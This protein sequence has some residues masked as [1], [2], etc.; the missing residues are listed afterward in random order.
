[1]NNLLNY[2]LKDLEKFFIKELNEKSFR[3]KQVFKWIYQQNELD[4][5]LMNNLSKSLRQKLIDLT[6]LT[7]PELVTEQKSQDGT[8]KW[9]FKLDSSNYIETVF[10]PEKDYS[11]ANPRGTLCISSQVGCAL[12]C[13][14]CATAQQG[15]NRNLSIAEIISQL[16]LAEF[17]LK[18]TSNKR[19]I[20]NI[21]FMGMGEPLLNF[22]NVIKSIQIMMDDFAYG[23][24]WKRITVSTAGVIPAINKLKEQCPV[25]LAISLHATNDDLRNELVPLN[26]KY[27]LNE[28][29]CS[30][31]HYTTHKSRVKITFEYV[32]I[33]DIND[34]V[35][36]ARKLV[37]LLSNLPAKVNLIPFNTFSQSSYERSSVESIE[38]FRNVL[39]KANLVTITRKTRGDDIDAACGQL[40]GKVKDRS[41]RITKG[42]K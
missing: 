8:R 13:S 27:P 24:S 31:K 29:L 23:L 40:A 34:S 21:V 11:H 32:L 33:K 30:C 9:L 39:V 1:M 16:W 38:R 35:E 37:K 4:F 12:N 36:H 17:L 6:E 2:N 18:S 14:F 7:M 25:N 42:K 10:I 20:N 15:F 3:A 5:A 41:K 22:E 19:A 26:K 28:L